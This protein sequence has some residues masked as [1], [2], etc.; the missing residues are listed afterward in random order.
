MVALGNW[1][2]QITAFQFLQL[3]WELKNTYFTEL[4]GLHEIVHVEHLA[5]CLVCGLCRLVLAVWRY[6]DIMGNSSL[7][8]GVRGVLGSTLSFICPVPC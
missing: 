8:D 4:R 1:F 6:R 7:K 3:K 5:L 2:S